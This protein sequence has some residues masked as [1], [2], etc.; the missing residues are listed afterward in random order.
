M[1]IKQHGKIPTPEPWELDV[2]CKTCGAIITL[3]GPH[4]MF[5]RRESGIY[6]TLGPDTFYYTCPD[7]EKVNKI[8]SKNIRIDIYSAVPAREFFRRS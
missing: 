6:G 7:C 2:T 5:K 4:D 1:K 3:E 8:D